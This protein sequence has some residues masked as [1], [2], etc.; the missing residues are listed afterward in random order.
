MLASRSAHA[1][2]DGLVDAPRPLDEQASVHQPFQMHAV[3]AEP[4]EFDAA[5]ESLAANQFE[6]A[7]S[8]SGAAH[9]C[10]DLSAPVNKSRHFITQGRLRDKCESEATAVFWRPWRRQSLVSGSS[11]TGV[12]NGDGSDFCCGAFLGRDW[13]SLPSPIIPGLVCPLPYK[14]SA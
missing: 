12:G 6:N 14:P 10:D 13:N 3:D 11:P 2:L 5:H 1:G 4:I 8:L 9:E 7:F